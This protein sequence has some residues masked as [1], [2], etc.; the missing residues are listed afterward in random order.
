MGRALVWDAT[1]V[2]MLAPTHL[3]RTSIRTGAAS[4]VAEKHKTIKY[5]E[6]D[7]EV[8]HSIYEKSAPFVAEAVPCKVFGPI[9]LLSMTVYFILNYH[10]LSFDILG[11]MFSIWPVALIS[12]TKMLSA[13][14]IKNYR[15]LIGTF[16]SKIHI[17]NYYQSTKD[18][19]VKMKLLDVERNTR[20]TACFI[21]FILFVDWNLWFIMPI[22]NN[23]NNKELVLNRTMR[24]QTCLFLWA[25]FD[26]AHDY[27]KWALIHLISG[28]VSL[29]GCIIITLFDTVTFAFVF[30]LIS[31]IEI[32]K[33]NIKRRFHNELSEDELKTR[34]I[35]MINYHTFITE[36]FKDIQLAF[37]ITIAGNYLQNLFQNSLVLYEL[38]FGPKS[39]KLQY[40]LM[41]V[42]YGGE[43]VVMSFVLEEIRRQ[44]EDLSDV[45]YCSIPWEQMSSENKKMFGI[46]LLRVQPTMEFKAACGLIAGVKPMI[47]ILKSTFSYYVMLKSSVG[48]E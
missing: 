33:Y 31:H 41:L 12:N 38:M 5:G 48:S 42:V 46:F 32:L 9:T 6:V 22:I 19:F 25:P 8:L 18:P 39:D 7:I 27:K 14:I 16:L 28:L 4:E 36:L 43:L 11:I 21:G 35:E 34:L 1:C 15:K 10:E 30:N 29:F 47:S 23:I 24:L 17:Y 3:P 40:G 20:L 37:G 26:Y 2:D 44:S 13:I 45:V